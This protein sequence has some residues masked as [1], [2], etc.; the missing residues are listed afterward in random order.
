MTTATNNPIV[1]GWMIYEKR[2]SNV[3]TTLGVK[4]GEK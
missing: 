2:D 4:V 3:V 1:K